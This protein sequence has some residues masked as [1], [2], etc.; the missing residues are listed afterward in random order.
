MIGGT[1]AV[2]PL[3]AGFTACLNQIL[4]KRVGALTSLLYSQV[5]ISPGSPTFHDITIGN[6]GAYSA[7]TGW[8]ACTGF[9]TPI[10]SA[11]VSALTGKASAARQ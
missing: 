5:A 1:S 8:D 9:G 6:N 4:G 2:A 7:K 11:I 3:W 10:G